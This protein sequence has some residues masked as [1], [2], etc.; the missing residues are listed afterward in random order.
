MS[1]VSSAR[2]AEFQS[3]VDALSREV[4]RLKQRVSS[5]EANNCM[6][7]RAT[8]NMQKLLSDAEWKVG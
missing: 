6:Q 3:L 5:L 4:N 7:Q 1:Q 2:A 8:A